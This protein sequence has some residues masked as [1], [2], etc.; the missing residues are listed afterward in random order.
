MTYEENA[1]LGDNIE[2][3]K[4]YQR[5][6]Y[7]NSS[8][9]NSTR[10]IALNNVSKVEI[11]REQFH[12]AVDEMAT[13]FDIEISYDIKNVNKIN[14]HMKHDGKPFIDLQEIINC[15]F[16]VGNTSK[17]KSKVDT[18]GGKGFGA[19][20]SIVGDML[21]IN[22]YTNKYIIKVEIENPIKQLENIIEGNIDYIDVNYKYIK[23]D[24]KFKGVEISLLGV[25]PGYF[26]HFSHEYI[27]QYIKMFT[28]IYKK[29][30]SPISVRVKGLEF[31]R[32]RDMSSYN[33]KEEYR[34]V[35]NDSYY[36]YSKHINTRY[37][38]QIIE[39]GDF[40]RDIES[41]VLESNKIKYFDSTGKGFEDYQDEYDKIQEIIYSIQDD[42]ADSSLS[43]FKVLFLGKEKEYKERI[44]PLIKRGKFKQK[45]SDFFG[46]YP[47]KNGV[48]L[49][50]RIDIRNIGGG[51]NGFNQYFG[52]F[53]APNIGLGV[54]RNSYNGVESNFKIQMGIKDIMKIIDSIVK[55]KRKLEHENP[56][57]NETNIPSNTPT[58]GNS[59]TNTPPNT[60]TG[61]N[62]GN[63]TQP[64][65]P[66]GE[67]NDKYRHKNKY[68][69]KLAYELRQ[70][71]IDKCMNTNMIIL[72][73]QSDQEVSISEPSCE[74][75]V[76]SMLYI[77]NF[78]K[79]EELGIN[80][81]DHNPSEGIDC[82]CLPYGMNKNRENLE[83]YG[84]W[85]EL[86]YKLDINFNHEI[87][88]IKK[89]ICWE[90]S[91]SVG[92]KAKSIKDKNN[93]YYKV[94][95]REDK[96]GFYDLISTDENAIENG[97]N[98]GI[99]VIELKKVFE[100]SLEKAFI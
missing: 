41:V 39:S 58:V 40:E 98:S 7:F 83:K 52:I 44:Y 94:I 47:E 96:A 20:L 54:D 92:K 38:F 31:N 90:M 59:G 79:P 61:G 55:K 86:K 32:L 78:I 17:K 97:E 23:N 30:V 4:K 88:E 33:S 56:E 11:I 34:V 29:Q 67:N 25:D 10:E 27:Y 60:P 24:T 14:I 35:V 37:D 72:K 53:D 74:N 15:Y 28:V 50:K 2:F 70:K 69:K 68:R 91:D 51:G 100:N 43:S 75:D 1:A 89:I 49:P 5:K 87:N 9:A 18:I 13:N 82:Y 62:K 8:N 46:I 63:N 77:L 57:N 80:I 85:V 73:N 64:N 93:N 66:T 21:L 95:K 71:A 42:K 36:T 3:N 12:N 6:E 84:Y 45:E 76:L 99:D 65:T 22:S 48:I 26:Y 81:I 19:K 16:K